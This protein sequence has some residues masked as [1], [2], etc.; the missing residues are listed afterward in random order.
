MPTAQ[1]CI[2]VFIV[3]ETVRSAYI[4]VLSPPPSEVWAGYERKGKPSIG[5]ESLMHPSLVRCTAMCVNTLGSAGKSINVYAV[6]KMYVISQNSRRKVIWEG[7][8]ADYRG[9]CM[10]MIKQLKLPPH[11]VSQVGWS[12]WL[13][14][15]PH[16]YYIMH[17]S[18]H[19]K[20]D[21]SCCKLKCILGQRSKM[22]RQAAATLLLLKYT[23]GRSFLL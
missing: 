9:Y 15:L 3:S 4:C 1:Y 21:A 23:Y 11:P 8:A 22:A 5:T 14:N 12:L 19:K 2:C 6:Y 10:Y 20:K 18:G 13:K 7:Q 17:R 16:T